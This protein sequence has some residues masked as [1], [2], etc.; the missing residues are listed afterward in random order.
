[1]GALYSSVVI[2]GMNS[3]LNML[4]GGVR[5]GWRRWVTEGMT[6]KGVYLS[7]A[8]LFSTS[9]LPWVEQVPSTM[10]FHYVLSAFDLPTVD[11]TL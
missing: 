3:Q 7:L 9:W 2:L 8:P 6:W 1:M 11:Q 10:S 4:L 5:F